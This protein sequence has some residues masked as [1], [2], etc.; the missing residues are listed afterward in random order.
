MGKYHYRKWN[1]CNGCPG[2]IYYILKIILGSQ[3]IDNRENITACESFCQF[4]RQMVA[5]LC[6]FIFFLFYAIVVVIPVA[7]AAFIIPSFAFEKKRYFRRTGFYKYPLY[8]KFFIYLIITIIL[9][10]FS[11][12][13]LY[14]G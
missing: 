12:I 6:Y 5:F 14:F 4:V 8:I 3:Y 13:I 9:C 7:I 11:F 2:K 1:I 10:P